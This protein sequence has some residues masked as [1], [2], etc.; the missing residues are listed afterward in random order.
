MIT[1]F[2]VE[3]QNLADDLKRKTEMKVTMV[4]PVPMTTGLC[5]F[6]ARRLLEKD[7]AELHLI[8]QIIGGTEFAEKT[9]CCRWQL[10]AGIDIKLFLSSKSLVVLRLN[11]HD[12]LRRRRRKLARFGRSY[13]GPDSARHSSNRFCK[14]LES[15]VRRTLGYSR[16]A[17]LAGSSPTDLSPGQ[18]LENKS[19]RVRI[20][21][22]AYKTRNPF[23]RRSSLETIR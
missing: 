2:K 5:C 22:G 21:R 13:R 3:N 8:G 20:G 23:H 9:I 10:S 19:N 17:R 12:L 16:F 11:R 1:G 7:M 18:L 14:Y 15:S 6:Q 4:T